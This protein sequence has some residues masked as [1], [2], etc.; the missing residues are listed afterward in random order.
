M[1][2]RGVFHI[3]T[4]GKKYEIKLDSTKKILFAKAFG[5]FGPDDANDFVT[6]YNSNL[7]TVNTK[8]FELQFD[9]K[10]LKVTGK[11]AALGVDMTN[12]LKA[13]LE[14]YKKDGFKH[15]IFNCEKNILM[16]MQLSRLVKQVG[17]TNVEFI[18]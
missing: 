3:T 12:M 14:M 4:N 16:K 2:L 9:C 11:D 17:L 7:K 18:A 8:E 1:Y 13:C 5:S 15:I 6:E 10:Q